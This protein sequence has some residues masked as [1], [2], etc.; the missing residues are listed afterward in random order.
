VN[1]VEVTAVSIEE[2]GEGPKSVRVR[3]RA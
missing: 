3:V 2:G 1:W